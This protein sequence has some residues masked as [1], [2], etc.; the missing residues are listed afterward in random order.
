MTEQERS[1]SDLHST[2]RAAGSDNAEL[3]RALHELADAGS[4]AAAQRAMLRDA[5]SKSEDQ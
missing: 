2:A 1:L 4:D 3:G 5:A